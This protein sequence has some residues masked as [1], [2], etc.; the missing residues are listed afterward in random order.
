MLCNKNRR[1]T[2][3]SSLLSKEA[4]NDWTSL[5]AGHDG[6]DTPSHPPQCWRLA[7][8]KQQWDVP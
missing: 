4:P 2:I 1:Q 5:R 6:G 7:A 3:E 8:R